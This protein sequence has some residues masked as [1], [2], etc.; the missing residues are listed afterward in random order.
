M[1]MSNTSITSSSFSTSKPPPNFLF[2]LTHFA[3]FTLTCYA[4]EQEKRKR[5][6][7]EERERKKKRRKR[8][9]GSDIES[10]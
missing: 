8:K 4:N 7:S 3:V 1:L 6:E 5:G 2:L 9:E 10:S